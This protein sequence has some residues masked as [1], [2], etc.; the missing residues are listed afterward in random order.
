[1]KIAAIRCLRLTGPADYG[2]TEERK[3]DLFDRIPGFGE[4]KAP[5][6]TPSGKLTAYYVQV[7]ADDGASGLFGPVF[8]ETAALVRSK[9]APLLKGRDA[10]AAD[11]LWDLMYAQCWAFGSGGSKGYPMMAISAVDLALWDLRGRAAGKP[12]CALLGG[13][14]REAIPCY[15]SMLGCSLEP[16]R[17]TERAREAVERGYRAQKWFFRY[18]PGDGDAGLEKNVALVRTV[19][20]AVGP[21]VDIMLDCSMAW[22]VEY[23]KS[24]LARIA[25]YRPRWLEEPLTPDEN[26]RLAEIRKSTAV[27]LATG[28]HEYTRW[29]FEQLVA[30]GAVDVL[31]PD[32]EWCGGLTEM[33]RIA[34]LAAAAHR[35]VFPHGHSIQAAWNFVAAQP[36]ALCPMLEFLWQF[37]PM[38]QHFHKRYVE[39]IDGRLQAPTAP[40]LGI[41]L[42]EGKIDVRVEL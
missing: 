8:E 40:G 9:I 31:Q 25:E 2:A 41:E 34:A 39:P 28:E 35:P 3:V 5:N 29:G 15:L 42:D 1:M 38:A 20:E 36:A 21:D 4:R 6:R 22:D 37:Q 19:R 13:E 11:V 33:R 16:D 7:D 32:P 12:V 30:T 26:H 23:T 24:V 10:S 17:V 14:R 27:P 18:G